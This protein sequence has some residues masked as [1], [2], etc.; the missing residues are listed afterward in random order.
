MSWVGTRTL[1]I[2]PN[3]GLEFLECAGLD[4]ELPLEVGT[5][6]ALHLIDLPKGEHA[7]PDNAPGLVGIRVIADDLGSNHE[8]GYEEAVP[9][10]T[11]SGDKPRL[12]SLQKIE[13]SKGHGGRKPR[14][15]EC[16]GNEVREGGGGRGRGGWWWLVGAVEEVVDVASAHLCGLLMAV[17]WVL[18]RRWLNEEPD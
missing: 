16:V 15:M 14:A 8:C 4:V 9:G 1:E 13:S 5:H 6:L 3:H 7:L 2:P 17:V 10:G 18:R 11:A 12:Q